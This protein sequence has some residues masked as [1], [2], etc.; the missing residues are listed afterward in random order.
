MLVHKFSFFLHLSEFTSSN[1]HTHSYNLEK[2]PVCVLKCGIW[3]CTHCENSC[4]V[5]KAW[6]PVWQIRDLF[7]RE[8]N[9]SLSISACVIFPT[10]NITSL[11]FVWGT[12]VAQHIPFH[13]CHTSLANLTLWLIVHSLPLIPWNIHKFHLQYCASSLFVCPFGRVAKQLLWY[14]PFAKNCF[15]PR[16][17][18][19]TDTK[20]RI[21]RSTPVG[22]RR[23][24]RET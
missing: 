22:Q 23:Q 2:L 14:T 8:I 6:R 12:R 15:V 9:Q 1:L 18:S 20:E 24:L 16:S 17:H 19:R 11:P 3:A 7:A 5:L 10:S 21:L 13:H 4:N